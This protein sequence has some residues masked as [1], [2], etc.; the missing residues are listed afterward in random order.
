MRLA[1]SFLAVFVGLLFITLPVSGQG[2]PVS[3][4]PRELGTALLR[5]LSIHEGKIVFRVDS[6]G[7]TAAASFRVRVER[8][9]DLTPKV[10]HYRLTIERVRIDECKAMLW[11]GVVI[12]IELE[13]DLG[14]TG[15]CTLSV[16]NPVLGAR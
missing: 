11:D 8:Q 12:E 3:R 6:N 7:C 15:A 16:G 1:W 9:E 10:P 13:K 5:E 4:T 14:L 2:L